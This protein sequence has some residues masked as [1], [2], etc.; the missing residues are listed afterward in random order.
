M[1]LDV[2]HDGPGE[3]VVLK[4]AGLATEVSRD[5]AADSLLR[6]LERQGVAAPRLVHRL[7]APAC[8]LVLVARSP[9]AAAHH[10]REIAARR[11]AKWYVARVAT[12]PAIATT[13]I[14]AHRAYL[15]T[16]GRRATVVRAGGKASFLEVT[17]AAMAAGDPGHSHVLVQLHTGRFHQIRA[18][19][20]LAGAPLV[21]DATYG[22]PPGRFYLEQVVLGAT[23]FG[24]VWSVWEAPEHADRDRWD[25]TLRAAVAAAALTARTAAPPPARAR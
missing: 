9:A 22:G 21:G 15:K 25:R 23:V 10:A 5:P 8:G 17:A 4:P 19:L 20:A 16:D 12:A 1:R 2:R 18:M 14:G 24:G 13:L 11:W 7:D 3:V 6:R